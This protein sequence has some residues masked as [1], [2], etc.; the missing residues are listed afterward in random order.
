MT[1][2]EGR[3][4][5]LPLDFLGDGPH[6][7]KLYLDDPAGGPTSLTVSD[8]DVTRAEPLTITIPRAGG[9]AARIGRRSK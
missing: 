6:K 7:A 9:F 4:L 2:K 8:A 1:A 3:E 5:S